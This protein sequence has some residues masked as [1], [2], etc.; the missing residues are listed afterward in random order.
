MCHAPRERVSWNNPNFFQNW[1]IFVT[2]HVSVWVE[3]PIFVY[4]IS[5]VL[6]HAPRERVSWNW[7]AFSAEVFCAVTLHVSVW[8]EIRHLL[9]LMTI[10]QSRSTW[11]CELKCYSVYCVTF[12]CASRSTWACELK[13]I[14]VFCWNVW[15]GKRH[16]PRERVSW[17][18]LKMQFKECTRVTL[19]VSVWVEILNF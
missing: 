5:G 13:F 4:C 6:R 16:A 7:I 10:F 12:V 9:H 19:H 15:R 1:T 8:V 17:N 3:I 18:P 11:A 14:P 2:L